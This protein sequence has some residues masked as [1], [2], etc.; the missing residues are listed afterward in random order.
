MGTQKRVGDGAN[1]CNLVTGEPF[2]ASNPQKKGQMLR[3]YLRWSHWRQAFNCPKEKL[4][5]GVC[6]E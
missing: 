4:A 3:S 6:R 2:V 1:V 5:V